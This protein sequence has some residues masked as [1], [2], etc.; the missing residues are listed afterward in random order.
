M[1]P[2][3][4]SLITFLPLLGMIFVV[5]TPDRNIKT[6]RWGSVIF[7]LLPLGLSLIAF[8]SYDLAKVGGHDASQFQLTEGPYV[9]FPQINATYH[10]GVDGISLPLVVLTTFLTPL[11]MLI[12]FH[13]QKGVK[14]FYAL[15]F[16]LETAVIGAFVSL[17]LS[18]PVAALFVL[19]IAALTACLVCFLREV[20]L[21]SEAER[22]RVIGS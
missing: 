9:W 14:A 8:S 17:D 2:N 19:A 5:L 21:A 3:I 20:Y 10:L 22:A 11:A 13:I 16:L 7:S 15:F 12:S 6:I 4:L 1:I 18:R